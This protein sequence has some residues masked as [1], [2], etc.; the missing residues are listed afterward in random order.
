MPNQ[1][2]SVETVRTLTRNDVSG[3]SPNDLKK[4]LNTL[5][6]ECREAVT[7]R[8]LAGN[9]DPTNAELLQEIRELRGTMSN[10]KEI[11]EQVKEMGN[12]LTTMYQ[13]VHQQQ[14]FMESIDNR[15]RRCKLV[16]TGLPEGPDDIGT[17]DIAKLQTV[18]TKAKCPSE[19]DPSTFTLRRLGQENN[20]R[21]PRPLHVTVTTP[22]Q[23]ETI[24]TA[25]KELK[26]AGGAFARV[27]IKKDTHPAVRKEVGRLRQ[28]EREEKNKAENQG[29]S[30]VYDA[31]QRI[32][33]RDGT[34]I[35]RFT[36]TFF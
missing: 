9:N 8:Q 36:P 21:G 19:M 28:R 22:Q 30:I 24:I 26:N 10:V 2:D 7:N 20:A 27:Y 23:R 12:R 33:T 13:I 14:L 32:L 17:G 25:A 15:E 35:D 18:L 5:L 11:K 16:I 1:N 34:I 31:K 4:A 29:V 6:T 3:L